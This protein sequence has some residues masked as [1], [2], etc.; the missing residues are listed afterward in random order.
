MQE[1]AEGNQLLGIDSRGV[2][3]DEIARLCPQLDVSD[4]PTWPILG[5]LYHGP[6][7]II[8]HDAVVWGFARGADRAG[9]EIHQNTRAAARERE[10]GR[11]PAVVPDRGRV[12]AGVVISAT[13]GWSTLVCGL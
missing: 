13:A 5:A 1:R 12:E 3:H 2:H 8:R 11:G 9:G 10:N 6:G 7:G 4:R